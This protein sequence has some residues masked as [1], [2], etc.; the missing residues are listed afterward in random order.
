MTT[1]VYEVTFQNGAFRPMR[2][3]LAAIAEGQRVRL[4]VE[5]EEKQDVLDLAAGVYKGLSNDEIN[6]VERI[7]FDRRNFSVMQGH[8]AS[9]ST[10]RPVTP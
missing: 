3:V 2:P 5:I 8:D 10:S 7:A 6:D 4:A 9:I 1:H